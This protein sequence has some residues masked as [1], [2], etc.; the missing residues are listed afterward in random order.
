VAA[1]GRIAY[2]ALAQ[3]YDWLVPDVVLTPEGYAAAF[4]DQIAAI[5][6]GAPV[7]DCACGPGTLAVGLAKRGFQ[8]SASDASPAMVDLARTLARERHVDI[9]AEVARW[10]A[11]DTI[12]PTLFT[13]VFCV[14]NS[15]THTDDRPAAL[16]AMRKVTAP[17]GLLVLTSRNWEL[18]RA[19]PASSRF[20]VARDG[21]RAHVTYDWGPA[22]GWD[23]RHQLDITV[24]LPDSTHS[25]RLTY[26][27][28]TH[29]ALEEDLRAAGFDLRD[30]TYAAAED[31]YL[32]TASPAS[33][34]S[35]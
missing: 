1:V 27:P 18:V 17:D 3:V 2:E 26:Y 19:G 11:L 28:F 22:R 7:L 16:E 35:R 13:A 15:L 4:E 9:A 24:D 33:S 23:E 31:R 5:E 25:E 12:W 14:G 32:V 10:E 6:P 21:I 30:S 8:V 34:R 20:E 29:G